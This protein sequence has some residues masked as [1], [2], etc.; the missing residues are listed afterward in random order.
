MQAAQAVFVVQ[1]AKMMAAEESMYCGRQN[2]ALLA[3]ATVLIC[4]A[5]SYVAKIRLWI[6]RR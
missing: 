5:H 2:M 1:L 6:A 4:P 3:M